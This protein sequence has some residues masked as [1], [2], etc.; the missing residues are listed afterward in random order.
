MVRKVLN[1]VP[2]LKPRGAG[3]FF[4]P[5]RGYG[6]ISQAYYRAAIDAGVEVRL[7]T[8]LTGLEISGGRATAVRVKTGAEETSITGD[9]ILSTIPLPAIVRACRPAPPREVLDAAAALRYRGMVLVYLVLETDRFTEYD[10]H[11]FPQRDL[12]MTRLS[13]PKNYSLEGP[14]GLTV[15]CAELPC[16][17]DDAIWKAGDAELGELVVDALGRAALPVNVPVRR[18]V[19]RRIREAYPIYSRDYRIYFDRLDEWVSSIDG[20]VTFG[21]QGLFVHDNTHHTLAM[22]YAL[23][24]CIDSGGRFDRAAWARHRQVFESHVVED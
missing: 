17:P 22:G 21:R 6:Q 11:Y 4:Y 23:E 12:V 10:A 5:R 19:T 15:L 14:S 7:N 20:L 13:E 18:V 24:Q 16:A 3:R 1:A 2:G 8:S 9:H